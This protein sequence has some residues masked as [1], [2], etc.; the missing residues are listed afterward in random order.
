MPTSHHD[1]TGPER[2]ELELLAAELGRHGL[3]GELC[4]PPG[5]LPYLHVRNPEASVLSER[6]YAQADSFW[7]SWAERIAG[8]D[9]TGAAAATLSRVL[10]TAGSSE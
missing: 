9:D 10:G 5:K 7:F 1:D 6:V 2:A 8:C 4:T 3:R